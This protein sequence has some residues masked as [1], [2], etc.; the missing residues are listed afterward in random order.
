VL[1]YNGEGRG[2]RAFDEFVELDPNSKS[3]PTIVLDQ[4]HRMVVTY[5]W[6]SPVTDMPHLRVQIG[7]D[8][9]NFSDLWP[10]AFGTQGVKYTISGP[11]IVTLVGTSGV[12]GFLTWGIGKR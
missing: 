2:R 12:Y 1:G 7:G 6:Y 9:N 3:F 8:P 10:A 11:A 5:F 4:E